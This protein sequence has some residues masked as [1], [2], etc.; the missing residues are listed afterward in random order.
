LRD[1][2]VRVRDTLLVRIDTGKV[3]YKAYGAAIRS[4]QMSRGNR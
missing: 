3:S 1:D 2:R 4:V